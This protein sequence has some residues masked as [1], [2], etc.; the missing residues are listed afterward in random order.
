[1]VIFTTEAQR[2]QGVLWVGCGGSRIS[3]RVF[4]VVRGYIPRAV[5][6]PAVAAVLWSLAGD[7]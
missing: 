5:T 2:P 1:M 4:R 6:S 7:I 3:F